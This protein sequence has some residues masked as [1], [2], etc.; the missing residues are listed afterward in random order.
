MA[1]PAAD[2]YVIREEY[3]D[4]LHI[5]AVCVMDALH[6]ARRAAEGAERLR[7]RE[8]LA[9]LEDR[10]EVADWVVDLTHA[11]LATTPDAH[12]PD[13]ARAFRRRA[14]QEFLTPSTS[15]EGVPG[16]ATA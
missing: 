5:G 2:G 12:S 11:H 15:T 8:A 1:K 9:A 14:L 16:L 6:Y 10:H 7:L 3:R 13:G 4:F